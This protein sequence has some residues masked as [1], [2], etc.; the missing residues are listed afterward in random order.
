[1]KTDISVIVPFLNEEDNIH[2]LCRAL[3][4][5]AQDKPYRLEVL[6]VD[7]GSTDRSVERLREYPFSSIQAKILRLSKNYGSHAALRAGVGRAQSEYCMFF[8]ADLQ[9]PVE[10]IG[11][12]YDKIQEGYDLVGVQKG[13][14]RISAFEKAFSHTY[15]RLIQKH[16]VASFPLGGINNVMF[17][18]KI[19]DNLNRHIEANSSIF[20]QILNMGYRFTL[21]TCNYRERAKGKSKWTLGKK[22]KLFIDS[23]VAFSFAPIRFI[24]VLGILLAVLGFLF[25][26][27]VVI[28]RLFHLYPLSLGWPTLVSVLTIGFGITNI[29]LGIIA[30]YLWRT[31][32]AARDR[33]VFLIDEEIPLEYETTRN[34]EGVEEHD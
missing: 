13:E 10:L 28:I 8:S 27:S 6:F 29:S 19:R 2:D 17:N 21:I 33:P 9:E 31:L 20:L 5:Y 15:A 22:V 32:D 14:V 24:S 26:L 18:A 4:G 25:G 16:A 1:M 12:L 34:G 30:E 11:L 7:D 3:D 23:F